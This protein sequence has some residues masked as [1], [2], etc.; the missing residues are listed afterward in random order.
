MFVERETPIATS[1][2]DEA[3]EFD[4]GGVTPTHYGNHSDDGKSRVTRLVKERV[5]PGLRAQS[6]T[7]NKGKPPL[8]L[9]LRGK[10]ISS[11]CKSTTSMDSGYYSEPRIHTP[12]VSAD[13][14]PTLKKDKSKPPL[15]RAVLEFAVANHPDDF[16]DVEVIKRVRDTAMQA[17]NHQTGQ[18]SDVKDEMQ[19]RTRA[20]IEGHAVSDSLA[21]PGLEHLISGWETKV[22]TKYERVSAKTNRSRSQSNSVSS[23]S[24]GQLQAREYF[25]T[26]R[27]GR[28]RRRRRRGNNI[29]LTGNSKHTI[30]KSRSHLLY[31]GSF[32][33]SRGER[34]RRRNYRSDS[35]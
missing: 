22:H 30:T 32:Y 15:A 26:S 31:Q 21:L 34:S 33:F 10:P 27:I 8:S 11:R 24:H 28:T 13:S 18:K 9:P 29:V 23:V 35:Q 17:Y 12:Q 19:F 7:D 14:Y 20:N 25:L 4:C 6:G 16:K 1:A 5:L 2:S 3:R